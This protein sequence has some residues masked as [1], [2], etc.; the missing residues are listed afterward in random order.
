MLGFR[1]KSYFVA[2]LLL[3]FLPALVSAQA[4]KNGAVTITVP[5]TPVNEYTTLT[6]NVV[7]NSSSLTVTASALNASGVFTT[8]LA[9][10]DLV[11]VI[12]MQGASMGLNDDTTYGFINSYNNCGNYELRQVL[13]VPNPTTINL[14]CGLQKAYTATGRVQVVRVPRYTTLTINAGASITCPS[15]NGTTGGVVAIE[16]DGAMVINSGGS[17][18]AS[19][20]GFRGG[21][22]SENLSAFGA[23]NYLWN[24]GNYGADKGEGIA[25]SQTDYDGF[26]GRF[27][28]G[29]P[30]NGGGGANAHNG[31]G[32][33]GGNAGLPASW[34]GRGNP[35]NALP[36][37]SAAWD[38]EYS[39]F[40]ASTSSGGGKGGYTFSSANLDA[41]L[42]AP[43]LVTWGG[44][45]RRENGGRGGRPLDY[46]SGRIFLGGGG[47][48]GDQ[49][50]SKGGAGGNGGGIIYITS[51]SGISGSGTIVSNGINGT[52]STAPTF[53]NSSA[54][55][56]GGGGA[57]G[58][59]LL[60]VDSP[61]TGITINANGGRG[62]NQ[63]VNATSFDAYGPG[64]GGGGGYISISNGAA[65][66]SA[67]GGQNGTTNSAGLTEFPPNG[68]TRGGQGQPNE[69]L[70]LFVFTAASDTVCPG[71]TTS[72]SVTWQGNLPAGTTFQWFSSPVG[73]APLATGTTF[74]TPNILSSTIF[75]VGTCPGFYRIAV[76]VE[77]IFLNGYFTSP[78]VCSGATAYFAGLGNSFPGTIVS[79]T[80]NFGDGS[81]TVGGQN[82]SHLYAAN[83]SYLV[84]LTVEDNYGCQAVSPL[85]VNVQPGPQTSFTTS[86]TTGC[87]PLPV[88]FTNT[89][90][91]GTTYNW[92]FGDGGTSTSTNASHTYT[93]PGTYNV[94]L[95][96][97]N[98]TCSDTLTQAALI[99]VNEK[100]TAAFTTSGAVCLGDTIFFTN[101]STTSSGAAISYS[102]NFGDG[103]PTTTL[104]NPFHSYATAG[105]FQVRLT[106]T[107]N[108]CT[109]DTLI[110][111]IVNPAP[112]AAF[113]PSALNGCGPTTINFT[114]TTT[115]SPSYLW[116]FGDGTNAVAASPSHLYTQN[117]VYS[118]TLIATQGSCSD[119][120]SA[121]NLITIA[122]KPT[123]SFSAT[124]VCLG[125][126]VRFTNLST[127]NGGT[128]S[129]N[130]WNFGDGSPVNN[131][132]SP[133][134]VYSAAGSYQVRLTVTSGACTDDTVITVSVS[135]APVAAFSSVVTSGCGSTSVV[136][137]NTTS[138]SPVYTWNFGDGSPTSSVTNPVHSYNSTGSYTV[139]LYAVQGSC[140]DTLTQT[141]PITVNVSP[142]SSFSTTSV[143]LGDSARF[144]NLSSANGG[145]I[146]GFTW[147]FG[148]GS[149][150]SGITS[151]AHFYAS[152]GTYSVQLL[153]VNGNCTDDTLITVNVNPSPVVAFTPSTTSGC[154]NT[155][156]QFSNTTTGSPAFTW[157]FGDGNTSSTVN[158]AHTYTTPGTYTVSLIAVQGACRDTLIRTNLITVAPGPISSFATSNVC[159]GDSVRFTN[160]SSGNG[161]T[162][163]STAWDFG[164][165]SP[166]AI[167]AA[168]THYYSSAGTY[169]V[170]LTVSNGSCTDD[171][172]ITVS[173]SPGPVVSFSPSITTGCGNTAV[174]FT[175][176]TTG[177]PSYSWNFGDGST[178]TSANPLHTYT[179]PGTYSVSLIAVQGTCS[180]TLVQNN[181]IVIGAG[182]TALFTAADICLGDTLELF[183]TSANTGNTTYSW[184]FGDGGSSSQ[185]SPLHLYMAAGSY[186][187]VLRATDIS[188][189]YDTLSQLVTVSALP[190]A[191]FS[192]NQLN[193]CDSMTVL[194]SASGSSISQ[195]QFGDGTTGNGTTVSHFYAAPGTYTVSLTATSSAGCSASRSFLNY[196]TVR[197][198]PQPVIS[199]GS[200]TICR[201]ACISFSG[202]SSGSPNSFVWNFPG[203]QPSSGF[204]PSVPIVCYPVAGNYPVTLTVSDGFCTTSTTL[205]AA[206]VAVDCSILPVA[207]FISSDTTVCIGDCI[208]FV[209]LSNNATGWS[210]SFT[211][212]TPSTSSMEQPASVCYNA[213]GTYPVSL[214]AINPAGSDTLRVK[215][216]ITVV[217][218][219]AVPVFVQSGDTLIAPAG[220][221]YQWYYNGVP[222][223]GAIGVRYVALLSGSYSLAISSVNGCSAISVPQHVSLVS[224][225]EFSSISGI[226]VYPN[227]FNDKLHVGFSLQLATTLSFDITDALGRIILERKE[228]YASGAVLQELDFSGLASG[229]YQLIIRSDAFVA[230]IKV[231]KQ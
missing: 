174:Q 79:W 13:S 230:G 136:F 207:D 24:A 5:N 178:S 182:P 65:T 109:D 92:N 113:T 127:G 69:S 204:G 48:A 165:G 112:V 22:L 192:A 226:K 175:N 155:T 17:V 183:N 43:G 145:T 185:V 217:S 221:I 159:L 103:S 18:D 104:N 199:S 80:W 73:G 173:V 77:V 219:P 12:Q 55:G 216:L 195:W 89:T 83:G 158:P 162:I 82:T 180:D 46:S 7:A 194:F 114:N 72:L 146:T 196:I 222:I 70:P 129:L 10:G 29:A 62:G 137:T 168:P 148:D 202:Q 8:P 87:G 21:A 220:Y 76:P 176:V 44:D 147:N 14:S 51:R 100:P 124:N 27:C 139:T 116:S 28:K 200:R 160:L 111:V 134:Y 63:Q 15:W 166:V 108:G 36:A 41:T 187:V 223:S 19:G 59:I 130:T 61:I 78:N 66:R 193:G 33:G 131:Q 3:L 125:D 169:S 35:D 218:A 150:T 170:Q 1:R 91:G 68:A 52:N 154:G 74:N 118:V 197:T 95:I 99:T 224:I 105:N 133:A 6:A 20:K 231:I 205:P 85:T 120:V 71:A 227:P 119:T 97:A 206:I 64:G 214:V 171:T 189:C 152:P 25:G 121:I 122:P 96:A 31:G 188:G 42:G 37:Y 102:W 93:A 138:S 149:P 101:N 98:G 208:S 164:D 57:G 126:T 84:T 38:L 45:Y 107:A 128:I 190:T 40:A 212:A 167:T 2:L 75:Y 49:N 106:A 198:G 153:V 88:A 58:T 140:S 4:G 172:V 156:V 123:S 56:A 181:L 228:F 215:G 16:V 143:C 191:V 30:A 54:D 90:T 132:T 86:T 32:G 157:N 201:D 39:G 11:M 213:A 115:G 67:T 163:T 81:P 135:P 211:G 179:T 26:S 34:T 177:S 161:G 203:A 60:D 225:D 50:D 144:I 141:L 117:G 94:S 151:P 184:T 209:S 210:W 23:L 229:V 110:S 47:G 9:A 186:T 53:L 142:I